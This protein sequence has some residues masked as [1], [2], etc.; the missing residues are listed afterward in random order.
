[1]RPQLERVEARE[2]FHKIYPGTKTCNEHL[3]PVVQSVVEPWQWHSS[4]RILAGS[5]DT[6]SFR[7]G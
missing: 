2:S 5:F 3:E 7:S 6:A 1:V 4:V